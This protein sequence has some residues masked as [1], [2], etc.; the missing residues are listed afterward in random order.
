MKSLPIL[1]LFFVLVLTACSGQG[2]A[3]PTNT[4][5]PAIAPAPAPFIAYQDNFDDPSSG[6]S[7]ASYV[8]GEYRMLVE[9]VGMV[10]WREAPLPAAPSLGDFD[11]QVRARYEGAAL[12]KSYGL[13][14]RYLDRNNFYIFKI[15][16]VIGEY[17]LQKLEGGDWVEIISWSTSPHVN[18]ATTTNV[19]RVIARGSRIELYADGKLLDTVVD[20][21]FTEGRI[22]L[23]ATN[24]DDPN[25]AEVFFDDLVVRQFTS[26]PTLTLDPAHTPMPPPNL[27]PTLANE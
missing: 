4:P 20:Q 25:G 21:T 1:A 22:G 14:F 15:D 26:P 12:S 18:L 17:R 19:L 24:G 2:S 8:D 3:E 9:Q 11:I 10:M 16:P 5:V 7:T 23:S 27:T 13:I 6:W